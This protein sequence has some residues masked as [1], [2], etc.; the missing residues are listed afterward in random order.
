[1]GRPRRNVYRATRANFVRAEVP[2]RPPDHVSRS[3]SAYWYTD[4]GM[5]RLSD[6]FGY[7][8]KSCD[9]LLEGHGYGY[10]K[11]YFPDPDA[12]IGWSI[13]PYVVFAHLEE[14]PVCGFCPWE[15][16]EPK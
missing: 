2:E 4:E 10:G 14:D 8:I 6:H 7:D 12:D 11:H 15:G 13:D 16:F 5:Y 1:M 9:W 3:G